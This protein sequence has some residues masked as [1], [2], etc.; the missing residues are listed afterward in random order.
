MGY[1][2]FAKLTARSCLP[3]MDLAFVFNT[4]QGIDFSQ[5]GAAGF[6]AAASST[7]TVL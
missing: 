7:T 6:A 2:R 5:L 1:R 4:L 3:I